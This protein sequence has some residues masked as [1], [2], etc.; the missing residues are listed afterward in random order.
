MPNL[1]RRRSRAKTMP[2]N[3]PMASI[4]VADASF[5]TLEQ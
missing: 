5:E 3:L 4:G 2:T 1:R